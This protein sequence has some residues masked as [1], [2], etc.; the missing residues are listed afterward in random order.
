MS[1]GPDFSLRFTPKL[2]GLSAAG[3]TLAFA[4]KQSKLDGPYLDISVTLFSLAAIAAIIGLFAE[5]YLTRSYAIAWKQH[6][7]FFTN[8]REAERELEIN[9]GLRLNDLPSLLVAGGLLLLLIALAGGTWLSY[10]G[11]AAGGI[12]VLIAAY[13][14]ILRG[15]SKSLPIHVPGAL[16]RPVFEA[17]CVIAFLL[18]SLG[19]LYPIG[20]WGHESATKVAQDPLGALKATEPRPSETPTRDTAIASPPDDSPRVKTPPTDTATPED[21][22]APTSLDA[23]LDA[24]AQAVRDNDTKAMID[25][26][27]QI[28]IHQTQI[29]GQQCVAVKGDKGD[30]GEK[31]DPGDPG[32]PGACGS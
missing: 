32:P 25:L 20:R 10:F 19:A 5:I 16:I 2:L 24:F 8:Q 26:R 7:H 11:I 4:A 31:G 1:D 18:F 9:P 17:A 29:T 13:R 28:T 27:R 14:L 3:L 23:L 30:P 22:S 15:A 6:R 21:T 12:M